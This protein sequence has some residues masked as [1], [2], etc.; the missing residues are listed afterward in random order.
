MSVTYPLFPR[1]VAPEETRLR[2]SH[3]Y[4]PCNLVGGDFFYIVRVS[5]TCAGIFIC[6]VMGHGVR[7]AL[8]TSMLRAF[9]EALGPKAANPEQVMTHLNNQL[10]GI[11][12]QTGTVLF[13]TALYCTLD[14]KTGQLRFARAGHPHPLHLRDNGDRVETLVGCEP[15]AGGLAL[16]LLPEARYHTTD[17]SLSPGDRILLFTDGIVEAEDREGREFGIHR[18]IDSLRRNLKKDCLLSLIENEVRVFVGTKEFK[19]DVCAVLARWVLQ[20][21]DHCTD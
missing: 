7:S 2:F 14:S 5:D 3:L 18:L 9:I 6:D 4:V 8:I 10:T 17:V 13:A 15:G 20:R 19:D 1:A 21:A 16:G 11:L 12:R